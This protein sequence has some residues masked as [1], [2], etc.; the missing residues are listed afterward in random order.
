M[1]GNPTNDVAF[2]DLGKAF[3]IVK[4]L[5]MFGILNDITVKFKHRR[6]ILSLQGEPKSSNSHREGKREREK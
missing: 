2:M 5:Q 4:W 1:K 3:N 6:I